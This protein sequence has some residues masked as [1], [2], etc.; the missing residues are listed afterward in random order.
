MT[1][2]GEP[3]M[4]SLGSLP[5]DILKEPKQITHF[6]HIFPT[7]K[8]RKIAQFWWINLVT[9]TI[10]DESHSA[11]IQDLIV[12]FPSFKPPSDEGISQLAM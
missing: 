12:G 6:F 2:I 7:E 5:L 1:W 4:T 9:S 10:I 3:P 8:L 11:H